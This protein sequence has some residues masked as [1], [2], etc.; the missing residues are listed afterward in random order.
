MQRQNLLLI[1]NPKLF[2]SAEIQYFYK[3]FLL[4]KTATIPSALHAYEKI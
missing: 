1:L 4:S 3:T 2:F